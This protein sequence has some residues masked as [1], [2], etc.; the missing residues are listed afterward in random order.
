MENTSRRHCFKWT[1]PES[2]SLERE[3]DLLSLDVKTIARMHGRSD[4]AIVHKLKADRIIDNFE[5]ARGYICS[6]AAKES[7][8]DLCFSDQDDSD[9]D[10][11]LEEEEDNESE[12]EDNIDDDYLNVIQMNK[13][14]QKRVAQLETTISLMKKVTNTPKRKPLR[15][16][17]H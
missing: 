9:S 17:P 1:T 8:H 7:C 16:Y 13:L 12:E 15:S 6:E 3:Y 5:E 11:E 2:L 4:R 14:L 10:Y